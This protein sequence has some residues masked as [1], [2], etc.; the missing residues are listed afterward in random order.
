MKEVEREYEKTRAEGAV[1]ALA[2]K[3]KVGVSPSHD[4]SGLF[5]ILGAPISIRGVVPVR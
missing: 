4:S 5:Y 3:E 2:Q 1:R